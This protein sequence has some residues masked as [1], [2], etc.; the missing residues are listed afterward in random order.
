[1][2]RPKQNRTNNMW[3]ALAR[4]RHPDVTFVPRTSAPE[5]TVDAVVKRED[6]SWRV[7]GTWTPGEGGGVLLSSAKAQYDAAEMTESR[8]KA[9]ARRLQDET[10]E[11]KWS[12]A[13]EGAAIR[14][15]FNTYNAALFHLKSKENT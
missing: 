12:H 11:L 7:V 9:V 8:L 15:G 10:P 4:L 3:Q 5:S 1:M 14:Y 2:P 6:G 13:L